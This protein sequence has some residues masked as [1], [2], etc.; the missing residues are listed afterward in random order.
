[1]I[2]INDLDMNHHA[3]LKAKIEEVGTLPTGLTQDDAGRVVFMNGLFVWNGWRW[4][5]FSD[6]KYLFKPNGQIVVNN[7]TWVDDAHI[8]F[9]IGSYELY[10]FQFYLFPEPQPGSNAVE[11]S[12]RFSASETITEM[13][14][15]NTH[16]FCRP[17][18]VTIEA[19]KY[20]TNLLNDIVF[21]GLED[22]DPPRPKL[23]FGI[24]YGGSQISTVT[25]QHKVTSVTGMVEIKASS[26]LILQR[27]Y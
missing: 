23:W 15:T 19:L 27:I 20:N 13:F 14:G 11:Y 17:Y 7:D 21:T 9:E 8:K 12:L 5:G 18:S 6:N 24:I 1:M 2:L 25:L 26:R 4:L 10:S 16:N 3:L 22:E